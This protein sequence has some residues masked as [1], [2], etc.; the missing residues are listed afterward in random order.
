MRFLWK[1]MPS[2]VK[3]SQQ[4]VQAAW[5]IGQKLW[6]RDYGGVYEAI[7]GF[8]WSQEAQGLVAAFSGKFLEITTCALVLFIFYMF[9][10]S[11]FNIIC[12]FI[13]K[14]IMIVIN[15]QK[16]IELWTVVLMIAELHLTLDISFLC[17]FL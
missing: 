14:S 6:V 9:H 5:K 4:E 15:S 2:A 8:D 12:I 7:R 1:S 10:Y 11:N 13:H 17:S 16:N 3:E